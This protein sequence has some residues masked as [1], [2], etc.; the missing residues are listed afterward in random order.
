MPDANKLSEDQRE[1]LARW[2]PVVVSRCRIRL[3]DPHAAQDVAQSVMERL[4]AELV[5]GKRYSLEYGVVVNKVIGWKIKEHFQ[6][7]QPEAELD[8]QLAAAA[9]DPFEEIDDRD[10]IRWLIVDLP[11]RQRQV[12]ELR[13]LERLDRDGRARLGIKRN[14]VDQAW[15]NAKSELQ[16][17]LG[18]D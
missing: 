8:E 10:F 13:L 15:H 7:I 9:D 5:R 16:R 2:Y 17:K 11:D 4:I 1:T 14:A 3:R 12:A 6:G 18:D